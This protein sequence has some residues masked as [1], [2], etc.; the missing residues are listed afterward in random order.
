MPSN[1]FSSFFSVSL[2]QKKNYDSVIIRH[3]SWCVSAFVRGIL[4]ASRVYVRVYVKLCMHANKKVIGNACFFLLAFIFCLKS[5]R[6]SSLINRVN[7][8]H[9]YDFEKRSYS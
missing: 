6:K 5:V 2:Y 3:A 1:I 4:Y 9:C 7:D 8:R